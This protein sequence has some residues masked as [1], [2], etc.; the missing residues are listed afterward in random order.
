[1][2]HSVESRSDTLASSD[3]RLSGCT[4]LA[5]VPNVTIAN[6]SSL[7]IVLISSSTNIFTRSSF[8]S[9]AAVSEFTDEDACITNTYYMVSLRFYAPLHRE[10][11]ISETLSWLGTKETKHMHIKSKQYRKK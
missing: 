5:D 6:M 1:L 9:G 11:I 7:L 4:T 3:I 2:R 8:D 10:K